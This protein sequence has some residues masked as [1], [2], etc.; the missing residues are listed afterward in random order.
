MSITYSTGNT[1]NWESFHQV[2]LVADPAPGNTPGLERW[3]PISTYTV[4]V[5][6]SSSVD[7]LSVYASSNTAQPHWKFAGTI[8]QLVQSGLSQSGNYDTIAGV[9]RFWLNQKTLL[10]YRT[11]Y[12]ANYGLEIKIPYWIRDIN[13]VIDQYIG[14]VTDSYE[15]KLDQIQTDLTTLQND[16]DAYTGM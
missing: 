13:I 14:T 4:P 10:Q 3:Y 11:D 1:A 2:S 9:K 16:F 5:L 12:Q 7:M 15:I 8:R 6:V